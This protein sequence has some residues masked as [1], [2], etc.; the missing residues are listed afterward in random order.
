MQAGI[1]E[2][3]EQVS[4]SKP[5]SPLPQGPPEQ[6]QAGGSL[7]FSKV[8]LFQPFLLPAFFIR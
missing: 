8:C 5:A 1:M 3:Q 7:P 6:S 2:L 4:A